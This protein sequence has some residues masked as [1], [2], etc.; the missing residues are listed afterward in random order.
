MNMW[1][2]EDKILDSIH[3]VVT[4]LILIILL[5]SRYYIVAV[6]Y[7]IITFQNLVQYRYNAL[8]VNVKPEA[9]SGGRSGERWQRC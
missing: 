6:I 8:H 5:V 7:D 4:D 2:K 3:T 9:N 1:T